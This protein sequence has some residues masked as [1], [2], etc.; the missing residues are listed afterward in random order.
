MIGE[1]LNLTRLF[2]ETYQGQAGQKAGSER[3][4]ESIHREL[5]LNE[6]LVAE[7]HKVRIT[8]PRLA[9]GLVA[10]MSLRSFD[11]LTAAGLPLAKIF[12]ARW[13]RSMSV[14]Q[15]YRNQF[16]NIES[17][18]GLI[19]RTY[20]RIRIQQIRVELG[21]KKDSRSLGYLKIL[22]ANAAQATRPNG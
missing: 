20:H 22:V 5:Q 18:S 8:Q 7:A 19:E 16:Q 2:I 21:Q 3:I 4:R 1:T 13:N 14:S 15:K 17:V 6:E 11:A 12:P 9:D 10:R